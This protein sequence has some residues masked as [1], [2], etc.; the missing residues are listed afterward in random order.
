MYVI[1]VGIYGAVQIFLSILMRI[2]A[3]HRLT[4]QCDRWPVI[5]FIKWMRQVWIS[6]YVS[7]C[8]SYSQN[9]LTF[10]I[11][12][13]CWFIHFLFIPTPPPFSFSLIRSGIMLD[14]ACTR[15][16]LITWS[17]LFIL[18]FYLSAMTHSL[19]H[20]QTTKQRHNNGYYHMRY[21]RISQ[22]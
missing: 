7:R 3:C 15:G 19:C 5:R 6:D 1:V 2:P 14:V 10:L 16:P 13:I 12:A 11:I 18:L 4:N 9:Y 8:F 20:T 21:A 22:T 17:N